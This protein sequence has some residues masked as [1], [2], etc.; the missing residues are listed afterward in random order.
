MITKRLNH[1]QSKEL[2]CQMK[3]RRRTGLRSEKIPIIFGYF[4]EIMF[5]T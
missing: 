1:I 5:I 3:K 2:R 4:E